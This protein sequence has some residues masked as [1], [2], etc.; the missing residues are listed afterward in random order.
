MYHAQ[1]ET[2]FYAANQVFSLLDL[3][4]VIYAWVVA[5]DE[6]SQNHS[7]SGTSMEGR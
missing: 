4:Y 2:P 7:E 5:D 6:F 3:L 1:G